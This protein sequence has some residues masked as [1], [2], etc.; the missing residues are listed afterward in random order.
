MSPCP[1]VLQKELLQLQSCCKGAVL[2]LPGLC[3][4]L[5]GSAEAGE[6]WLQCQCLGKQGAPPQ[7][8]SLP[9][10][11]HAPLSSLYVLGKGKA[12]AS[13]AVKG[14]H[15]LVLPCRGVQAGAGLRLC[16]SKCNS[17]VCAA[18][19]KSFTRNTSVLTFLIKH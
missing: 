18:P 9:S 16:F 1:G 12:L 10:T 15:E 7:K 2:V 4:V 3:P 17:F 8:N 6:Q 14:G 5:A 13:R 11:C 19:G